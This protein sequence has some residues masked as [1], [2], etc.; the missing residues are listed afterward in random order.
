MID[1]MMVGPIELD[2]VK[3]LACDSCSLL[4][5]T[6]ALSSF[7]MNMTQVKGVDVA[8]LVPRTKI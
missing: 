4:L 1:R 2:K 6:N 5:G 7:T 8:T 3:A